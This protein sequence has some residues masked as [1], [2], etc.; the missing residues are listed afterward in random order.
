MSTHFRAVAGSISPAYSATVVDGNGAAVD[1]TGQTAVVLRLRH[2]ATDEVVD[3]TLTVSDE[4]SGAVARTWLDDDLDIRPGVWWGQWRVTLA[5]G[6]QIWPNAS[7]EEP[8]D[9]PFGWHGLR[10][11]ICPANADPA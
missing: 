8:C 10:V 1:L 7:D 2:G 5:G 6:V 9:H 4:A 11:E 3:F